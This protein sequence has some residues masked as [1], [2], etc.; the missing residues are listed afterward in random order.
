MNFRNVPSL[1]KTGLY[2]GGGWVASGVETKERIGKNI[3]IIQRSRE[4]VKQS[5]TLLGMGQKEA[6]RQISK[7][8]SLNLVTI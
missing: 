4:E 3:A 5:S 1:S 2:S 6:D 7:V 8:I